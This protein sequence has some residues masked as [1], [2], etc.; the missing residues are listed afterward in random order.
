MTDYNNPQEV[1]GM[2]EADSKVK[3][4]HACLDEMLEKY[5]GQEDDELYA[6]A[7]LEG[8][9]NGCN[10][11]GL[12]QEFSTRMAGFQYVFSH[13]SP[14]VVKAV[15]HT[16]Y[17]KNYL[18]KVP[19]KYLKKSA[20][21]TFKTEAYMR[22]HYELRL[23]VMTGVPEYRQFGGLYSY[24]ELDNKTR[25]TMTINALKAGVDSW[26]KDLDRYL[27]SSLIPTYYPL[28]DYISQL[29]RW[30]GRDRIAP[31]AMRVTD[32]KYWVGC[33]HK[34]MLSMVAQWL[35]LN[36]QHGNA[37]VPIL[38][39][40]QGSGK[41][42]FCRR[43]LPEE[44]QRYYNDN[45]PMKN[46]KDIYNSMSSMALIN[47]DEFDSIT[48]AKHPILKY[49]LSKHDVKIRPPYGKSIE[50][51][52]RFASFIATTNNDHPLTDPTGSRRFVCVHSETIDNSGKLNYNQIYAQLKY[53]LDNG[54]QYWFTDKEN[55]RIM[56]SN[57]RFRKVRDYPT[58]LTQTFLPVN[59]TPKDA[60]FMPLTDV[61]NTLA[62]KYAEVK[63]TNGAVTALG[64]F[65]R[66]MGYEHK[67][68]SRGSCYRITSL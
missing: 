31:L 49:L 22:E 10:E 5:R 42:T 58:M 14:D 55:A 51:R 30:D 38:I 41:T 62:N 19:M 61:M 3:R 43:L 8:L 11:M 50:Q 57:E 1:P 12:S 29:P 4:F 15:F 59:E 33:F 26:D 13:I 37:I 47:I 2:S 56:Q 9:A 48:D 34:W 64:K 65:L 68:T 54:E 16:A 7:V 35:G 17:L 20:L 53:E 28:S 45:L 21:L 36:K 23:N 46:D 24:G 44:L 63:V 25:K 60:P 32:D 52:Q 66:S 40:P 18:K 27:E 39:G 67:K 6:V